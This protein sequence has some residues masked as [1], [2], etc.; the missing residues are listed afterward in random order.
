MEKGLTRR[1]QL[2]VGTVIAVTIAAAAL[3]TNRTLVLI[4]LGAFPTGELG[5]KVAR[6]RWGYLL[7]FVAG[8]VALALDPKVLGRLRSTK[9]WWVPLVVIGADTVVALI[10]G[11]VTHSWLVG[12]SAAMPSMAALGALFAGITLITWDRRLVDYAVSA[13]ALV[14][15]A[16]G[17]EQML[18][19]N[20]YIVPYLGEWFAAFDRYAV[21]IT[22]G[23]Q[24]DLVRAEGLD[25]NPNN[26]ALLGVV[27]LIWALFIMRKGYLR[28]TTITAALLVV[29][30]AQSRTIFLAVLAVGL[31]ALIDLK[32]RRTT[33]REF[34]RVA[35]TVAV[36]V[37]IVGVSAAALFGR[38][39]LLTYV[40]RVSSA[41]AVASKGSSADPSF[42]GRVR[43]WKRALPLIAR[44]PQGYYST[45]GL[46]LGG[47]LDSEYVWR[48]II[49]GWLYFVVFGAL[50]AWLVFALRPPSSPLFGA[51]LAATLAVVGITLVP[52]QILGYVVFG[53]F[54]IGA[55]ILFVDSPTGAAA[56]TR[57]MGVRG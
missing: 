37:A 3:L 23:A 46:R 19:R 56:R 14:S 47:S 10:T 34:A 32:R 22:R 40:S 4:N 13:T 1:N 11:A 30:L 28:T 25:V 35:G 44:R 16:A 24:F 49:G 9:W 42:R 12:L 48:L 2:I 55:A 53:W 33:I 7:P 45:A 21:R 54:C 38:A 15:A 17:V 8:M 26:Y 31:I 41:A 39:S 52:T 57:R 36:I 5:N 43:V 18:R 29:V 6:L 27:A 51:A 20:N 50:L